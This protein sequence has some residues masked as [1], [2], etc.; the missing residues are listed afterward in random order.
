MNKAHLA[1][2]W[3]RYWGSKKLETTT[4]SKFPD[5]VKPDNEAGAP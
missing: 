5:Y 4:V 2:L 1:L 3:K